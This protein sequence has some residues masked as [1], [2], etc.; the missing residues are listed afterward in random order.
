MAQI[1]RAWDF[2]YI[3]ISGAEG[4]GEREFQLRSR[5]SLERP[6]LVRPALP[7]LRALRRPPVRIFFLSW[8][9]LRPRQCA[10][11]CPAAG[12]GGRRWGW[13]SRLRRP[14]P[15]ARPTRP[16]GETRRPRV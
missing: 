2:V 11:E 14:L 3:R 8:R 13:L 15:F 7:M 5:R 4:L 1:A 10:R 16:A 12:P 9:S 6:I